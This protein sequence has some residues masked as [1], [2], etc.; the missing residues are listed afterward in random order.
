MIHK[1]K[2][3]KIGDYQEITIK[4]FNGKN[5]FHKDRHLINTPLTELNDNDVIETDIVILETDH[6]DNIVINALTIFIQ[7]DIKFTNCTLNGFLEVF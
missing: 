6:L 2:S 3:D 7:S 5:Y 1:I 4:E